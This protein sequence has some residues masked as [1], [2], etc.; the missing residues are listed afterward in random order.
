VKDTPAYDR[1]GR[2]I[3]AALDQ[4]LILRIYF[5]V[6]NDDN[7]MKCVD[8]TECS[9]DENGQ[10]IASQLRSSNTPQDT[11]VSMVPVLGSV[12]T[13][14]HQTDTVFEDAVY[15]DSSTS[16]STSTAPSQGASASTPTIALPATPRTQVSSLPSRPTSAPPVSSAT[17][18]NNTRITP[19]S[20]VNRPVTPPLF[21]PPAPQALSSTAQ[22]STALA[23]PALV[24]IPAVTIAPV[25]TPQPAAPASVTG[26]EPSAESQVQASNEDSSAESKLSS[27]S[28]TEPAS[29]QAP[30]TTTVYVSPFRSIPPPPAFFP[31]H[32]PPSQS[33]SVASSN[34]MN[35]ALLL[36]TTASLAPPSVFPQSLPPAQPQPQ[37]QP[38]ISHAQVPIGSGLAVSSSDDVQMSDGTASD[39]MGV[40]AGTEGN[41]QV[42]S[43]SV[44]GAGDAMEV[45]VPNSSSGWVSLRVLLFMLLFISTKGRAG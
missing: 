6:F 28:A 3:G 36:S 32:Q 2:L 25:A 14:V 42:D 19:E 29:T 18:V 31:S 22:P 21:D 1:C 38:S 8:C 37:P 7:I 39:N 9:T 13:A 35:H 43:A 16:T 33:E 27:T 23:P 26:L 24:N 41:G 17:N 11:D 5:A 15:G 10:K 44:I 12:S 34:D 20:L 4:R 40:V 45:D 30:T